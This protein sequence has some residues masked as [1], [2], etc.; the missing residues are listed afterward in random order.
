MTY[1]RAVVT[2]ALL[3]GGVVGC[4]P[5]HKPPRVVVSPEATSWIGSQ[6]VTPR[7]MPGAPWKK[8]PEGDF[9]RVPSDSRPAA[10]RLL[11]NT[12]AV[13]LSPKQL[14]ALAPGIPAAPRPGLKPYLLRGVVLE[15]SG[16]Q[17]VGTGGLEVQTLEEGPGWAKVGFRW[18]GHPDGNLVAAPVIAWLPFKPGEVLA[19]LA[20]AD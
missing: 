10:V 13:G 7:P 5:P 12:A 20:S 2:A 17:I 18:L 8:L 4:Q 1:R 6:P 15:V 19:G 14:A 11:A 3:G 16:G 9:L